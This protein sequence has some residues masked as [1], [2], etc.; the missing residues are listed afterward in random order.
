[1][2]RSVGASWKKHRTFHSHPK[3][4]TR[5]MKS[6]EKIFSTVRHDGIADAEG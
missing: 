3:H 5:Q 6:V 4:I 1:M 2:L